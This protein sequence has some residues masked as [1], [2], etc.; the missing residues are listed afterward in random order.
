MT[1][2][3]SC[4]SSSSSLSP[5]PVRHSKPSRRNAL[6]EPQTSRTAAEISAAGACLSACRPTP[7]RDSST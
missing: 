7:A 2:R 4:R 1:I 5:K 6:P 3:S